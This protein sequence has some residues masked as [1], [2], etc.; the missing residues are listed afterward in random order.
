MDSYEPHLGPSAWP[1]TRPMPESPPRPRRCRA[2]PAGID[3][4]GLHG[5]FV[6]DRHTATYHCGRPPPN[7][8]AYYH[9]RREKEAFEAEPAHCVH[10]TRKS[11]RNASTRHTD[12]PGAR[13][14]AGTGAGGG[15]R[16]GQRALGPPSSP[17]DVSPYLETPSRCAWGRWKRSWRRRSVW[18]ASTRPA[19]I[20]S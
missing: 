5:K 15:A 6:A 2:L 4:L 10:T 8:P 20:S 7:A 9:Q 12:C 1:G 14:G 18:P 17:R 16:C 13:G 11:Q 3:S 19:F